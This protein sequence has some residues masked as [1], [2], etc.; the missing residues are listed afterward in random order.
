MAGGLALS[1]HSYP[2]S[3]L[4][5]F[6]EA[7]GDGEHFP[8]CPVCPSLLGD[9]GVGASASLRGP[10]AFPTGEGVWAVKGFVSPPD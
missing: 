5:G 8:P 7:C 1:L 6:Q 3:P 9:S 2:S 4:R 10:C